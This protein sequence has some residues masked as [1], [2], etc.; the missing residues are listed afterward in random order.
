MKHLT[1]LV[2]TLTLILNACGSSKSAT[3]GWQYESGA[4]NQLDKYNPIAVHK[5][6]YNAYID[7]TVKQIDLANH[8]LK[9][10]AANY[11]GYI[12]ETGSRRSIIKVEHQLLNNAIN[13]ISLLGKVDYKNVVGQDVTEEYLDLQM[14]LEN[15]LKSR[16]RYLELLKQAEN[17]QT[18]LSVEKELERITLTIEQ[19]EGKIKNIDR[20]THYATI[21]INLK[22]KKKLGPLGFVFKGVYLGV[23]WLFVRG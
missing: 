13:D 19:L 17:V 1:F 15:A 7:L 12:V 5:I 16:E 14:R 9:K 4:V 11:K 10:I 6:I 20:N 3:S 8:Q 23:K 21:T 22:Q 18:A 2:L